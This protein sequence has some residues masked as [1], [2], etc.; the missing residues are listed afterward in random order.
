MHSWNIFAARRTT[1]K[2]GF[3]K[4]TTVQMWCLA[5]G[6]A[7]KWHFVLGLPSGSFEIPKVG[8]LATLGAHNFVFRPLI[9][10]KSKAKF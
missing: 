4:L 2:F 9:D 6:P 1:G 3:T 5:M 10:M 7:P 8:T